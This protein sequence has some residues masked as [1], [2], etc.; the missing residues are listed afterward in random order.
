MS[1][2]L[3]PTGPRSPEWGEPTLPGFVP[4]YP[5]PAQPGM[6][7][8]A[9]LSGDS[10]GQA[11]PGAPGPAAALPARPATAWGSLI[12]VAAAR[13]GAGYLIALVFGLVQVLL[14]LLVVDGMPWTSVIAGPPILAGM[15]LFGGVHLSAS[16]SALGFSAEASGSGRMLSLSML[17]VILAAVAAM[18]LLQRRFARMPATPAQRWITAGFT[19]GFLAVIATVI[20]LVARVS[21]EGM[22]LSGLGVDLFLGALIVGALAS[23]IGDVLG[24]RGRLHLD[25]IGLRPRHGFGVRAGLSALSVQLLI[26]AIVLFV[27][28]VVMAGIQD[29][30]SLA[31]LPL[32]G[33]NGWLWAVGVLFGGGLLLSGTGGGMGMNSSMTTVGTLF[34]ANLSWWVVLLIVLLALVS[35][36]AAAFT[37]AVRRPVTT[38]SR[39]WVTPAV[40][41][42]A[43]VLLTVLSVA[44]VGGNLGVFGIGGS[45]NV[46][47]LIGPWWFLAMA[48]WAMVVELGARYVALPVLRML[49]PRAQASLGRLVVPTAFTGPVSAPQEAF[50]G[51]DPAAQASPIAD[52][53]PAPQ[54]AFPGSAPGHPGVTTA[55]SG[56]AAGQPGVTAEQLGVTAEQPGASAPMPTMPVDGAAPTFAPQ[57]PYGQPAVP[58]DPERQRKIRRRVIWAVSSVG[59]VVVLLVAG[60]ITIA[61]INS[62]VYG[63][64]AQ[65]Q[66]FFDALE[67]G[68]AS[69]ALAMADLDLSPADQALLTDEIYGAA[70]SRPQDMRVRSTTTY[71]STASVSVE[72]TQGD[73]SV[74]GSVLLEKTGRT[75]V[76]F[77][78]WR[79]ID[80]PLGSLSTS[81]YDTEEVVVNGQ[82]VTLEASTVTVLP[83]EYTVSLPESTWMESSTATAVVYGDAWT[84]LDEVALSPNAEFETEAKR[85]V[86]EY[87]N[88]CLAQADLAP[89]N[90]PNQAWEWRTVNDLTWTMDEAPTYSFE[91]SWRSDTSFTVSARGGKATAS[92]TYAEETYSTAVGDPFS[93]T[94]NL[95]FSGTIEITGDELVFSYGY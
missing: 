70:E 43:A 32:I 42:G 40:Y 44:S 83:G 75:G 12:G 26:P 6:S 1:S 36:L 25:R 69:D 54:S 93:E 14:C 9:A 72:F 13:A 38:W 53:S 30:R 91:P 16:T 35:V 81:L 58:M 92:G 4:A 55:H 49:S 86:D 76:F 82:T 8:P 18:A 68:S 64:G 15:G 79:I 34:N 52:M 77:D 10:T 71:G 48:A 66:E 21:L 74:T 27:V 23:A 78:Q 94:S 50:V 84:T 89:R 28:T 31:A 3:P 45:V 63:P 24:R 60:V 62:R 87:L 2:P 67:Q 90:C 7:G 73:R 20:A 61:Q 95:S 41:A 37:L 47:V 46:L 80:A 17:L 57:A 22:T 88:G 19:G 85:V 29:A 56:V 65:A 51:G 11:A 33:L 39:V 5:D 59:A